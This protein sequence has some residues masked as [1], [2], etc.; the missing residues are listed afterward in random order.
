MLGFIVGVIVLG[1]ASTSIQAV[2]IGFCNKGFGYDAAGNLNCLGDTLGQVRAAN[3]VDCQFPFQMNG[4]WYDTC[5]NVGSASSTSYYC[6]VD[7]VYQN[8]KVSCSERCPALAR[9]LIKTAG[10]THTSC[11][12][13][14]SGI[15]SYF[16]GDQQTIQA[17]VNAHNQ[18]RAN[19]VPSA[20]NMP[21]MTWDVGLARLSQRRAETCQ[22]YHEDYSQRTLVNMPTLTVGQNIFKTSKGYTNLTALWLDSVNAWASEK[23]DFTYG[24]SANV[25][26]SV[27]HYTQIVNKNAVR[28]GCGAANCAGTSYVYCDYALG[29][30]SNEVN[31]PYASGQS[32]SSCGS[33]G[34]A[35]NLCKCNLL[36]LNGGTLDLQNCKCNC[37]KY[38]SGSQCETK[39]CTLTD[40]AYGCYSGI[41]NGWCIYS[42]IPPIC[43]KMCGLCSIT[44]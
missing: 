4:V 41:N 14:N 34:S 8:R 25:F 13:P 5:T 39:N 31:S 1:L 27:G 3:E 43:P 32:C 38:T 35:N 10:L 18:V 33:A 42:N 44:I 11:M 9:R 30:M 16:P 12:V 36:C 7:T 6:S 26:S 15:T 2:D 40:A 29:Q 37:P 17:I 28:V 22:F 21:A 23:S 19:V 20:T 24:S